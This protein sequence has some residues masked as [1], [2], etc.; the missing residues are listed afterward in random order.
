[1]ASISASSSGPPRAARD[2]P[3]LLTVTATELTRLRRGFLLWY[4]LLA[5]VAIAIPL[6]L[7]SLFSPEGASG[8]T[9]DTFSNVSF[10]FWGTLVPMTAGLIAALAV[11][12]DEEALRLLLS[13]AVPRWRYL[14]GKFLALA[15]LS[16]LSTTIFAVLL[17]CG[18][19][20]N[21]RLDDLGLV[22]SGS[23]LPWMAGLASMAIALVVAVLCGIGPAFAAGV[24]GLL[25]G[26]LIADKSFWMVVPFSWPMRVVLPLAGIGP[27]GIALPHGSPLHDT[28]V[29]VV[30]V[31]LSLLVTAAAL[32]VGA[33]YVNRQEV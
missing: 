7:G 6:Y 15:F 12:A 16:L 32:A 9:W 30:A 31:A 19:A 20:I 29:V 8:H 17:A 4:V 18:A 14:V 33:W 11:R 24:V 25:S 2:H 28:S 23:Y 3:S 27:S 26:A 10:E 1:M 13:Y 5:P 22:A 21:G